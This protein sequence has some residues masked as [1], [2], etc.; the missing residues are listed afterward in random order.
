MASIQQTS[1]IA[2]GGATLRVAQGWIA[3]QRYQLADARRVLDQTDVALLESHPW[4][5]AVRELVSAQIALV[6]GQDRRVVEVLRGSRAARSIPSWLAHRM[7]I[8]E[9]RAYTAMGAPVAAW[10]AAIRAGGSHTADGA[11]ALARAQLSAGHPVAAAGT[12]RP[13]LAEAVTVRSE[14][15]VEAWLLH[16]Q[17][18]YGAGDPARG[19]RSLDRALRLGDRERVRLPFAECLSWPRSVLGSDRDL[20]RQYARLL[21]PLRIGVVQCHEHGG[22]T[23]QGPLLAGKLSERELEVLRHLA[24]MRTSEEIAT[25]MF[26]SINTVKTHLKSIYRKLAVS[27]RGDA[28]RRAHQ[29]ELL[30]RTTVFPLGGDHS[31]PNSRARRMASLRDET[32]SLR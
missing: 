6:Q 8:M 30:V 28:V 2:Q 25:E 1:P 19:R 21:E 18:C 29:L 9:S 17:S 32:P 3:L 11:V 13:T 20:T 27:R 23:A 7:M 14:V 5:A 24:Q 31:R 22:P 12:L 26:V 15:R 4:T 16:T 10:Q